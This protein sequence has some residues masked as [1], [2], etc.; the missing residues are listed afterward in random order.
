MGTNIKTE[1]CKKNNE[2][3]SD[4]KEVMKIWLAEKKSAGGNRLTVRKKWEKEG[5]KN[6]SFRKVQRNK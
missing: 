6:S 1:E 2:H 4:S 3:K 5:R